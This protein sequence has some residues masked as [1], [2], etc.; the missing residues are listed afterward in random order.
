MKLINHS[1]LLLTLTLGFCFVSAVAQVKQPA[2]KAAVKTERKTAAK[3]TVARP[4]AK[5][6]GEAAT[7]APQDTARRGG[8]ATSPANSSLSEEIVVTTTYKPVLADAVKIRRNPNLE[9]TSPFKAPL[10]YNTL[11]KK[12]TSDSDIRP[13]VAM[14]MPAERDSILKNNYVKAGLGSLKTTYGEAYINNGRDAALQTGLYAKHFD[15]HGSLYKQNEMRDD[16][17]IF[18]KSTGASNTVS[19]RIDYN[20]RSNYFYGYDVNNP[21]ANSFTPAKQHFSTIG[22]EGEIA[23]NYKD[24]DRAFTYAFK[25]KG[26]LFSN[27]FQAR[28]NN[29]VVSGFVNQTIKQFYAGLSASLDLATQKDSLYSLNNSLFRLNPYLKFQGDN[30]KIDAGLNIVDQ[31]GYASK[32]Y[33]FPAARLELQVIP[34]YVRLFAEAKGDVNRT[35]LHDLSIINPYLGQN[36]PIQNSVDQLDLTLGLKGTIFPGLGFKA[37]F[38]RNSVKN[39]PLLVSNFN[40]AGTNNKFTIVYDDGRARISGFNGDLDYK[41]SDNFD[42][43]GRVEFKTYSLASQAQPWNLPKF[44]LTAGTVIHI[45][46]KVD[47]NGSLLIRGTVR[48]PHLVTNGTITTASSISSFADLSGGVQYKVNKQFNIFVQANNILNTS[49]QTWLYYP[50]YG[51][52]IFGGAGFSF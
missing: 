52:N 28:E 46:N 31:F 11:D 45:S 8:Q 47:I 38:F 29:L 30:Y 23:N 7:R 50:D 13:L 16:I 40:A 21:P 6:L 15:Q 2:K 33:I 49:Y 18:G 43:F 41:A 35:S 10:A 34:Q 17:G 32:F 39:L 3:K 22:A 36:L 20:Y 26:Y 24:T 27:A 4:A 1:S 25:A 9:D 37:S 5:R 48:D 12:L 14:P 19:G 42:L 44:K 51:F